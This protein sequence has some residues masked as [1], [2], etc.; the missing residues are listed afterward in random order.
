MSGSDFGDEERDR[1]HEA[2][3]SRV[4]PT[5]A[6]LGRRKFLFAAGAG[7]AGCTGA[8]L[9]GSK[10]FFGS[11]EADGP[12]GDDTPGSSTSTQQI[13]AVDVSGSRSLV[14][15]FLEGGADSANI[16][17]PMDNSEQGKSYDAY[18]KARGNLAVSGSNLLGFG[19]GKFGFN[20]GVPGLSTL[21]SEGRLA[22]IQNVGPLARPMTKAD[23]LA[24][25][26]IPQS[27]FAHDAQQKLWQTA[28]PDLTSSQGWGGVVSSA[29]SRDAEVTPAFSLNGSNIWQ[30]AL[31]GPYTR[32]SP[33]V[34]IQRLRGYDASLQASDPRS[35]S[36]AKVLARSIELAGSS[37]NVFERDVAD[38]INGSIVTTERLQEATAPSDTDEI[39]ADIDGNRLGMQ[40][41]LVARLLKNRENLGMARQMFFVRMGGWDTH[42]Q[43]ADRF[44]V[45]LAELDQAVTSFQQ[46]VDELGLSDSVTTF[47]ASDFG[48]TL[49]LNGDGTDHGWGGHSF[50]FGGAVKGGL[51][52]TFPSYA[53]TNNPDDT[54]EAGD[55]FAGRLIPTTAVCQYGATMARWMGLQDSQLD[56]AF[57]ELQNFEQR[58]I[59]FL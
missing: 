37:A 2:D 48:R 8:V 20:S 6:R 56:V 12:E 52:G 10:L 41:R 9:G 44:P 39:M 33:T 54:G 40:L 51:Y 5:S 19:D 7:L 14:C 35:A 24:K 38:L 26:S 13:E 21:A 16:F 59:G 4:E 15:I 43:Q 47:T 28:R 42:G 17:I 31:E 46:A 50:V 25:K 29:V 57:P 55:S 3:R 45:L 58:D 1:S 22:V 30:S 34:S 23:F 11:H 53:T 49:T 32:L 27:L 18:R 36:I